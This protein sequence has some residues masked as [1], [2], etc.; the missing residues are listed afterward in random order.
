MQVST[1]A[2]HYTL[3]AKGV[4]YFDSHRKRWSALVCTE[5]VRLSIACVC[6]VV[7][8]YMCGQFMLFLE[9][10]LCALHAHTMLSKFSLDRASAAVLA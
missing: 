7:K 6:L 5:A 3:S 2:L 10:G 9:Q 1:E 8:G 4:G